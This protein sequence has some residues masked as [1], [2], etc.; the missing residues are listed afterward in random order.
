MKG[1]WVVI[2]KKKSGL[3]SLSVPEVVTNTER[4]PLE[5]QWKNIFKL[6]PLSEGS[7]GKMTRLDSLH[8]EKTHIPLCT[9]GN[10]C[11]PEGGILREVCRGAHPLLWCWLFQARHS[12]PLCWQPGDQAKPLRI[13]WLPHPT[14]EQALGGSNKEIG[15]SENSFKGVWK[16]LLIECTKISLWREDYVFLNAD[17]LF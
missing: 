16:I 6:P 4:V 3:F 1:K 13:A 12:A 7:L 5:K 2:R 8:L 17:W 9:S 15:C 14:L 11:A 10:H